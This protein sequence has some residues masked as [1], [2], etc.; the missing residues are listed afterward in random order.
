MLPVVPSM[1][2]LGVL[3]CDEVYETD[4]AANC[5]EGDAAGEIAL[6]PDAAVPVCSVLSIDWEWEPGVDCGCVVLAEVTSRRHMWLGARPRRRSWRI[7]TS[8]VAVEGTE[9]TA[10]APCIARQVSCTRPGVAVEGRGDEPHARE[11]SEP[12]VDRTLMPA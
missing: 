12:G 9:M 5:A 6:N 2:G 3:R 8:A 7:I 11:C 4:I 10:V 1:A